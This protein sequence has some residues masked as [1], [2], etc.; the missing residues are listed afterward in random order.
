MNE[1][2]IQNYKT[3]QEQLE[4]LKKE[5]AEAERIYRGRMELGTLNSDPASIQIL[6]QT[7]LDRKIQI[8]DLEKQIGNR[9]FDNHDNYDNYDN[10][11][12]HS[13]QESIKGQQETSLTEY[14]RNPIINWLQGIITKMEQF[15]EKL[16]QKRIMRENGRV[17]EPKIAK[18]KYEEY[19][20]I[21]DTDF[22]YKKQG[23]QQ[24]TAHQLFVDKISGNGAYHT[25][26][27]NAQNMEQARTMVNPEK[28]QYK[29][30]QMQKDEEV[31]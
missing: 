10:H 25:Y 17:I 13:Y 9:E 7:I 11:N 2:G 6:A 24:K 31:R 27:K 15:S 16:E 5:Q 29:A 26:G 12:Y 18:T 28:I 23:V 21:I 22:S 8:E 4:D 19:Q 3:L 1:N 20:D 30:N 14:H